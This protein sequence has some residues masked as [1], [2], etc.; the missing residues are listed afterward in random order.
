MTY[1]LTVSVVLFKTDI[2]E[3]ENILKIISQSNLK[4]KVFFV[5]NSPDLHLKSSIPVNEDIEYIHIGKNLGFGKGHN[6]AIRKSCDISEFHL[7]LNADVSFKAMILEEMYSYM[8]ENEEIGLMAP[9][10][11]NPD[12]TIQYSAKLLP[13][14]ANLIFR[15]FIPIKF[16]KEKM[17][18]R[19]E[20]RS[21]GFDRIIEVPFLMGCFLFINTK[22]FDVVKGFD[23]R[24]FMYVED[25][26]LTRRIFEHFKTIYYPHVSIY[27]QHSKGSYR[28]KRL[29]KYHIIAA[30]KY[31]NKWGWLF[32]RGRREIN[33]KVLDQFDTPY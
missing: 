13:T 32:D 27:H 2:G 18:N 4:V 20:F 11:Y 16:I 31:F 29:L 5:D 21:F 9:K 19:Y 26:D 10:I 23:E 8:K 24:F 6:I 22:V 33:K 15:R 17:D 7:I 25:I 14:P 12:E 1:N 30:I 3:I 28:N